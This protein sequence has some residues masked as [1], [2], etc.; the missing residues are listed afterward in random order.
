MEIPGCGEPGSRAGLFGGTAGVD[1]GDEQDK[2]E[3]LCCCS[4]WRCSRLDAG[5]GTLSDL[6]CVK[7]L[8]VPA[9]VLCVFSSKS[10]QPVVCVEA[11]F[12]L[13]CVGL[14]CFISC[15]VLRDQG[16]FLSQTFIKCF[17][18]TE[19]GWLAQGGVFFPVQCLWLFSSIPLPLPSTRCRVF[20]Y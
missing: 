17:W 5:Q 20:I 18:V 3:I 19:T 8:A 11:T 6:V 7:H 16:L 4:S 9:A 12:Y 10:S 13:V 1:L 15:S 14:C 2:G